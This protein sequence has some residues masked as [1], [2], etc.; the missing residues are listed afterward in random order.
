[1]ENIPLGSHLICKSEFY[2]HHGIYVGNGEVVHY[3]GWGDKVIHKKPIAKTSINIFHDGDPC[4]ILSHP[5]KCE[6]CQSQQNGKEVVNGREVVQRALSMLGEDKY[7]L[8]YNNCEH[9]VMWCLYGSKASEQ[10]DL[11]WQLVGTAILTA[12]A[13]SPLPPPFGLGMGLPALAAGLY[14]LGT[15]GTPFIRK[16]IATSTVLSLEK[17]DYHKLAIN[18]SCS[19]KTLKR[20]N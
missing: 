16:G 9:F 13:V 6:Y 15:R 8:V 7:H 14:V 11:G 5:C 19:C 3:V 20:I 12:Y 10:S 4:F 18:E 17:H 1:M 2:E